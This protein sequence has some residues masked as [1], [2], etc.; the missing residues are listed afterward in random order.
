MTQDDFD[1]FTD[2]LITNAD[3]YGK[4]LSPKAISI[5]FG[6]LM[7]YEINVVLE[8]FS[9]HMQN[10][11]SGQFMPKPA[12]IVRMAQGSTQDNAYAAWSI[13]EQALRSIG[14]YTT[15]VFDD[16]LIHKTITELGGWIKLCHAQEK[17]LPFIARDFEKIYRGYKSRNEVPDYPRTLLGVHEAENWQKGFNAE[18][19]T[20]IGRDKTKALAVM[21]GGSN[22]PALIHRRASEDE[23]NQMKLLGGAA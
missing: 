11:D 15:V 4:T 13:V 5:Y 3:I 21:G 1:T 18:P 23:M 2:A 20:L 6:S 19:P 7:G 8:A 9:R 17:D 12:D 22:K 14:S 16:P 10:P